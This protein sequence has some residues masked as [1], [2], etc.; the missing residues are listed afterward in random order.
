MICTLSP[1][2]LFERFEKLPAAQRKETFEWARECSRQEEPLVMLPKDEA[3]QGRPEKWRFRTV[4]TGRWV[5][6][7]WKRI[8]YIA[9]NST[10]SSPESLFASA[11]KVLDSLAVPLNMLSQ[12]YEAARDTV[13][14]EVPFRYGLVMQFI[15][16][17]VA[18]NAAEI[19][20][21]PVGSS[22]R[23][24]REAWVA[25]GHSLDAYRSF[26]LAL[27][28]IRQERDPPF[29]LFRFEEKVAVVWF[30]DV[31]LAHGPF[32]KALF[33]RDLEHLFWPN[34]NHQA[35]ADPPMEWCERAACSH[36]MGVV[37]DEKLLITFSKHV[38]PWKKAQEAT[39]KNRMQAIW[40]DKF[41]PLLDAAAKEMEGKLPADELKNK[42]D[43]MRQQL[44][45]KLEE[46]EK[47]A[48]EAVVEKERVHPLKN[49]GRCKLVR[50]CSQT[51]QKEDWAAV[52][53][54]YCQKRE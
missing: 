21:Q 30:R 37:S 50:Y 16:A 40:Q 23:E 4:D 9:V 33:A 34:F 32:Y 28:Q 54:R 22:E 8:V 47:S 25:E 7:S 39:L 51:C 17:N 49:C 29:V 6:F 48:L 10:H 41:Q 24:A 12:R 43:V 19:T 1:D 36:T 46:E 5:S 38:G 44:E 52:H 53:K 13:C 20:G 31:H 45:E 18:A 35:E 26:A 11:M 2:Q 15:R 42:L 14:V 27:F 3:A